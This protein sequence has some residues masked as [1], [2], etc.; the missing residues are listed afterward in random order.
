MVVEGLIYFSY[1][2]KSDVLWQR[3]SSRRP[4]G[5]RTDARHPCWGAYFSRQAEWTQRDE[6]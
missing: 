2:G 6:G 3:S 5:D 4:V 1:N